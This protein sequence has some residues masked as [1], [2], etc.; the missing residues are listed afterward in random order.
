MEIT[1]Q[2]SG[3]APKIAEAISQ[4]AKTIID[5]ID[6]AANPQDQAIRRS[7]TNEEVVQVRAVAEALA[8]IGAAL[9]SLYE[10]GR[11]VNGRIRFVTKPDRNVSLELSIQ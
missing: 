1:R 7:A 4:E 8:S 5:N 11:I 2:F 3:T 6:V 10:D 9:D